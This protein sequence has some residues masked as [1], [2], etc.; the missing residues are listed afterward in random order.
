MI[1]FSY[2]SNDNIYFENISNE[3]VYEFNNN[4]VLNG[5]IDVS[6]PSS[7]NSN[8]SNLKVNVSYQGNLLNPNIKLSLYKKEKLTAYD[9]N[10]ILVDLQDYFDNKLT[11]FNDTTYNLFDILN[12]SNVID[13]L[14]NDFE[15]GGYKF[16]FDLY[17]GNT[18]IDTVEKTFIVKY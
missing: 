6:V 3:L 1:V 9:Q 18:K 2:I 4:S 17:D 5:F 16:V 15:Y 13:L 8:D 14:I 11:L 10:Y 7:I 12:E